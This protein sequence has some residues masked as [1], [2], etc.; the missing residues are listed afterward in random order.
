[1]EKKDQTPGPFG[2][3]V[4]KHA[5]TVIELLK[6]RRAHRIGLMGGTFDPV[7]RA[8]VE[9]ARR[10]MEQCAL[11]A[12][13]FLVSGDRRTSRARA[14]AADRFAMLETGACKGAGAVPQ[15]RGA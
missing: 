14:P 5:G 2:G 1:M 4:E 7:H 11:D 12:V 9:M 3:L 8:H 13:L 10:A 15:P 6:E